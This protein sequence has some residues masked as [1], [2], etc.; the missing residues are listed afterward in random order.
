MSTG[1]WIIIL[2]ACALGYGYALGVDIRTK[3][4]LNPLK[5]LAITLVFILAIL[6]TWLSLKQ[7]YIGSPILGLFLG[8]VIYNVVPRF[9][10]GFMEGTTFGA[11]K[12]L[13]LAIILVGATL[14]FTQ[15]TASV[16]ALP[17]VLFNICL[18]F[19]VAFLVGKL[20]IKQS[21]KICTM[22]GGGTCICGGTAIATLGSIVRAAADE[23]GF[24]MTAI[25]LFDMF[26]CLL[27]PYLAGWLGLTPEQFSFLAGTAINDTSSVAASAAQYAVLTG[28][29]QYATG[30]LSV[31]LVRTTMLVVLA[32]IATILVTRS[33]AK[34]ESA[35]SGANPGIGTTLVKAFPWFVLGFM[36]MAILNTLGLFSGVTLFGGAGNSGAH[37]DLP[38]FFSIG[39]K[40]MITCALVAVGF[41]MKFKD[42]FTRG[43]KTLLLGGC[44]WLMVAI[45]S[46]CF[47]YLFADY[48]NSTHLFK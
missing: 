44:T 8:M 13:P 29:P 24:A 30:A 33:A 2:I 35:E 36:A 4:K 43:Y 17:L 28:V 18:S 31:K 39:S 10:G 25:F 11:K 3:S 16:R 32:L 48:V 45:S 22:V 9:S 6:A 12:F 41:K 20:A 1:I 47:I 42:L 38:G 23:I 26:S 34:Q 14:N 7:R 15:I 19:G 46:L 27:Y 40:F 21:N 5:Y 37:V